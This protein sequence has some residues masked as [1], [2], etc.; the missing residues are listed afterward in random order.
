MEMVWKER[1]RIDLQ[2]FG[3]ALFG[4]ASQKVGP[5]LTGAEDVRPFNPSHHHMMQRT[6]SIQ[7]R[8]P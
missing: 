5:V 3:L 2:R 1:P 8:L 6:C 4:Q 7:S